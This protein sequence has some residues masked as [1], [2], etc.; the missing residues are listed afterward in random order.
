MAMVFLG[1]ICWAFTTT[2]SMLLIMPKPSLSDFYSHL[3]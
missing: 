3:C 1:L 2:L